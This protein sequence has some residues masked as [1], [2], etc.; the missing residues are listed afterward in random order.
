VKRTKSST[1]VVADLVAQRLQ[2]HRTALV[3]RF[4]EDVRRVPGIARWR[5]PEGG[6][7]RVRCVEAVEELLR[8]GLTGVLA[9][10]PRGPLRE[11]LVEPDVAPPGERDVVAEPLVRQFVGERELVGRP[12]ELR[13]GGGLERVAHLR[14]VVD[15]CTAR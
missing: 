10:E 4:V 8:A 11:A 14:G 9:P 6:V 15:Q 12:V 13:A 5:V 2:G 7:L 3:D 1:V